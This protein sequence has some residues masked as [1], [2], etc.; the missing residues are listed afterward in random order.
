MMTKVIEL[1][2]KLPALL[3]ANDFA[4]LVDKSRLSIRRESHHLA[5]IAVMRKSEKLRRRCVNDA[6]RVRVLNLAQHLDR[7]PFTHGPHRR[8]EV[9]KTVNRQQRRALKRRNKETARE[10][11]EMMLDVVKARTQ[12]SFRNTKYTREL[13]TQVAHFRGVREAVFGLAQ[14]TKT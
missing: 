5:F 6:R 1:Q 14:H 7:V 13:F 9:A 2:T 8:N 4:K 12:R 11:R 3:S 10:M